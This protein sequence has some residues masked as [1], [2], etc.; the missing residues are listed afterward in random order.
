MIE[1]LKLLGT[2]ANFSIE[3]ECPNLVA[4]GKRCRERE[5][6]A[7]SLHDPHFEFTCFL[8]KK[9]RVE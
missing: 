9:F 6:V 2:F 4:W 1:L 8:K 7:K 5:S 3:E